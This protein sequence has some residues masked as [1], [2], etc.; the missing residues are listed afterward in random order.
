MDKVNQALAM[1]GAVAAP[2]RLS[3]EKRRATDGSWSPCRGADIIFT[4]KT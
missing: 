3:D 4:Y 1:F 2:G